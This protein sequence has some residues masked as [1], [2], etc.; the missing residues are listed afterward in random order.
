MRRLTPLQLHAIINLNGGE[1]VSTIEGE[2]RLSIKGAYHYATNNQ[3]DNLWGYD[4]SIMDQL[5]IN[6]KT[7]FKE[8]KQLSHSYRYQCREMA[9]DQDLSMGGENK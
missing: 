7:S 9:I 1:T 6:S 5:G 2:H 8:Y 4:Y 3:E